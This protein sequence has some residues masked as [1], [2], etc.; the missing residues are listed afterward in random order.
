MPKQEQRKMRHPK[1]S[2]GTCPNTFMIRQAAPQVAGGRC[3]ISINKVVSAET[4]KKIM[5][6]L[7]ADET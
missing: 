1:K 3:D 7:A 2:R 5:A 4:A 6:I